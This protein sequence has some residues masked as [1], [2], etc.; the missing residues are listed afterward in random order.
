MFAEWKQA[1]RR[2]NPRN[3]TQLLSLI[4]ATFL[5]I[6]DNNCSAYYRHMIGMLWRSL[7]DEVVVDE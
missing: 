6:S 5:N 1:V 2:G 3:E 4:N 7:N